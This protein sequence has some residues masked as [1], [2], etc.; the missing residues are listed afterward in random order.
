[1]L[2]EIGDGIRVADI[3]VS[4][5]VRILS[6]PDEMIVVATLAKEEEV[7][8]P[9]AEAEAVTPTEPEL[10][11]ERGKKEEEVPEEKEKK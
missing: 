3:T 5:K 4:D 6:D 10:A 9:A 8:V 1:V 7:E 11:V 2:N